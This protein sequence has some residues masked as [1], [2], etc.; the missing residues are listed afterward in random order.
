MNQILEN[1]IMS[2]DRG[3][4]KDQPYI[5]IGELNELINRSY[6][7]YGK[8]QSGF[9]YSEI[10]VTDMKKIMKY[11][12]SCEE[13]DDK[14]KLMYSSEMRKY[15]SIPVVVFILKQLERY[16]HML[17][18]Y[19]VCHCKLLDKIIRKYDSEGYIR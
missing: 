3:Y 17:R 11:L 7:D 18:E 15:V 4:V 16:D 9:Y 12:A 13:F 8:N 2:F 6:N 19:D 1:D 5:T 14:N 10:E